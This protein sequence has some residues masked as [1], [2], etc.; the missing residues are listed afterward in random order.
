MR[1]HRKAFTAGIPAALALSLGIGLSATAVD[2]AGAAGPAAA[3]E[4]SAS[5]RHLGPRQL[6]DAVLTEDDLPVGYR[7]LESPATMLAALF[8][9]NGMSGTRWAAGRTT[10]TAT[11]QPAGRGPAAVDRWLGT[12]TADVGETPLQ[13]AA[14]MR[15][16]EG[17][18]LVQEIVATGED[19][20]RHLVDGAEMMLDCCPVVT[21]DDMRIT[22]SELPRMPQLGDAS[23]AMAMTLSVEDEEAD[24]DLTVHGTVVVLAHEDVFEKIVLL[25]SPKTMHDTEFE[26]IAENA[27]DKL[28]EA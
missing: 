18:V 24:V 12:G 5:S 9:P 27:F 3:A 28:A 22:L 7:Q 1:N 13:M 8:D 25:G 23:V 10:G 26:E 14:F 15:G 11:A 6:E 19:L 21:S 4:A 17:P 2:V 20:A 16:D